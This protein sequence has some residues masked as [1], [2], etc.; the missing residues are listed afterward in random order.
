MQDASPL[1][2]G[3][4]NVFE[5]RHNSGFVAVVTQVPASNASV[6]LA[7]PGCATPV[8]TALHPGG[9]RAAVAIA[10]VSSG[11]GRFAAVVPVVR[12][13][14]VVVITCGSKANSAAKLAAGRSL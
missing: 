8:G 10:P 5:T 4:V 6:V 13:C 1:G 11:P 3:R 7:L 9:G 14:A 2:S 12:Q